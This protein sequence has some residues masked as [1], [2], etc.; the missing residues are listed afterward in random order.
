MTCYTALLRQDLALPGLEEASE[1]GVSKSVLC[2]PGIAGFLGGCMCVREA[3]EPSGRLCHGGFSARRNGRYLATMRS[4]EALHMAARKSGS[5][6]IGVEG[7]LRP[8][9]L[10]C[11]WGRTTD[12][13]EFFGL[14]HHSLYALGCDLQQH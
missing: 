3:D 2:R 5:T 6:V 9:G 14:R 11:W 1:K 7:P 10:G 8:S 13:S 12:A 4:G